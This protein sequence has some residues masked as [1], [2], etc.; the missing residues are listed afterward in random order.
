LDNFNNNGFLLKKNLFRGS[1]LQSL[2]SEFDFIVSCLKNSDEDIN[3]SWGSPL[4]K[5][6][7]P[8]N[9]EVIHTHNVTSYSSLM[10]QMVQNK[11]LLNEVENIIGQDIILHHTK[12]FEKPPKKGSAFPLHQDWS[13]FPTKENSMIAAVLHLSKSNIDMGCLRIVPRSHKLGRIEGSDGHQLV[14]EIHKKYDLESA[15]PIIAKPGDVLFFH[16]CSIHGSMP[17]KSNSPRKTILLQFYSG[18]DKINNEITHT[19]AQLVLRGRNYF[20]TRSSVDVR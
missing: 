11:E 3:A 10:L 7:D 18:K 12:L 8:L 20:A 13:Y 2:K 4:T 9:T 1:D 19:N 17:N 6:I 16:C 5:N 14:D 15:T